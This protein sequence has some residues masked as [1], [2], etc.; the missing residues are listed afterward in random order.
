LG[1]EAENWS[2]NGAFLL[3]AVGSAVGIGNIWRFPYLVGE[4]GGSAFVL[5][6]V[7]AVVAVAM[8]IL[9]AEL[10]IGRRGGRSADETLRR[11]AVAEGGSELWRFHGLLMIGIALLGSSFFSVVSGWCVAYVPLALSGSFV[12]ADGEASARL[13][14]EL[15]G[16]PVRIVAWHGVFMGVTVLIVSGGVKGGL[17]RALKLLMPTL[18]LLLVG[19]VLYASVIG[20]LGAGL[21][22]LF[23]PD[24]SRI[25]AD[26]VLKALGQACLSLSVG[27]GVMV[28]Y[29]AY[30]PKA[31]S[32]P[33]ATAVIALAD[34][35]TALL[36]GVAIFPIVAAYGL[37][38][39]EGPGLTF[40]TLPIAFGQMPFGTFVGTLFFVLLVVAA[41]GSSIGILETIVFWLSERI[42]G[43]KW[44]LAVGAGLL[45]WVLGIAS[46]LSFNLWADFKPLSRFSPFRDANIFGVVEHVAA[47]LMLP[48][49]VLLVAVFAGW[50]MGKSST[51]DELVAGETS[52]YRRWRFLIRY[53]APLA[54]LAILIA[55]FT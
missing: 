21:R 2:S 14:S 31:I 28:T 39:D 52:A 18:F 36:A 13:L 15:T 40:V 55:N 29:G 3:A 48:V 30:L 1:R 8:P 26:A 33:R 9:T 49:S 54:V 41:L 16:N 27:V 20:D 47:N 43:R 42:P 10:L 38:P 53:V 25:D 11:L 46:A 19:L 44:V 37:A 51:L 7:L 17:E 23:A 6:Y 32:I 24:F 34:T 5:V 35:V 12:G 4:N 50:V 22:F 45:T